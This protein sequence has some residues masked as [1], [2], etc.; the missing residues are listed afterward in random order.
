[1]AVGK[2]HFA[3]FKSFRSA[4]FKPSLSHLSFGHL[5]GVFPVF[6]ALYVCLMRQE[7]SIHIIQPNQCNQNFKTALNL[8]SS[9]T[10]PTLFYY[11]LFT[12]TV[13]ANE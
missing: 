11:Y 2:P 8:A 1:M 10:S 7:L 13:D 12:C 6:L 4:T 9:L 5:L 3:Y